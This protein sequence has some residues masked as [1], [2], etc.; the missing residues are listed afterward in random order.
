MKTLILFVFCVVLS[1]TGYTQQ[2]E[3]KEIKDFIAKQ[4]AQFKNPESSPLT[5]EDLQDFTELSYYPIAL[6]Y[7]V[8]ATFKRTPLEQPFAM[9]TSTQRKPIYVKYGEL[10]FT[11][12]NQDLMLNVYQNQSLVF[13]ASYKDYLFVPFTDATSGNETYGG[14]RYIDLTIP[15]TTSVILDFNKSYNPYCAYNGKY[16]CPIPPKENHLDIPI[17]A[18]VK[19]YKPH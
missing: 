14:G 9:E 10:H 2:A 12:D 18:G 5:K 16:S 19:N 4:N 13:D 15:E 3:I 6:S 8:V 11:L 17:R 7:R 1:T